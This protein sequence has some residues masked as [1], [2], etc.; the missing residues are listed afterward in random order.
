MGRVIGIDLGTTNSAAAYWRKR[1]PKPIHNAKGSPFTPSVVMIEQ[2][3][4]I[5]GQDAKERMRTG[6]KNIV[7]STKRF[8]GRDYDDEIVQR[9]LEHVGY[10][11]RKA[12]NGEVEVLLDGKYYSPVEIS[13]MIL[14]QLKKDAEVVL[15]EEVTHAVI[16]VPAYF[17]QRQKNATREAGQLAG[18]KVLR[19]INEPTAAAL[20]FGV[21]EESDEPQRILVYDLGGGTF[22]ISILVVSG[23]NFDVLHIAGDN[24]LGGDDFDQLIVDEMLAKIQREYGEDL[25]QDDGAKYILKGRA[26]QE[27]KIELS[28]E[29]EAR[30]PG[31]AAFQTRQGKPINIDY[32]ITRAHFEELVEDLVQRSVDITYRALRD[33]DIEVEDIDRVLLVGGMTRVPIIRKRLK[34]IFGDKIEIDVDPMQCVALGAAV[35]TTIPIEWLCQHCDAVNKGIE[36]TCY[37][38]GKPRELGDEEQQPH[39]LCDECGKPNRQG[40]RECWNCGAT[41]GAVFAGDQV[42][43]ITDIT[44]MY[45]GVET[46]D[47][48]QFA[49]VIPKSTLYPTDEPFK[50]EL[51]TSSFGREYY[52]LPVYELETEDAPREKWEHIAVMY[53]DRLPPGLPSNTPVMVEMRIDGDGILTVRSFV[54]KLEDET[55]IEG[56]FIFAGKETQEKPLSEILENLGFFIFY[57]ESVAQFPFLKK[58][59]NPGQ[60]EQALQLVAEAKPVLEMEDQVRAQPLLGRMQDLAKNFPV[61]TWDVFWAKWAAEDPKTSAI[62]RS[63]A[64]QI[65]MQMERAASRADYD[66]AN[67]HLEQLRQKRVEMFEK[68]PSDLLKQMR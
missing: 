5:V 65:I 45:I 66:T 26:E 18:L 46:I 22:D 47:G 36:E 48:S 58:Y 56:K 32:T 50:R 51:F 57:L 10:E 31:G 28:R 38:C 11:T 13:A 17:G 63:Q 62:D 43:S 34:E 55:L 67:Q 40:R 2:G 29:K 16:T 3:R 39:I 35:Q 14:E 42:A 21:E 44:P 59:L 20:A 19:I 30:I 64:E 23:G 24:F 25:S 1:R 12:S 54:R 68:L 8:I 49:T 52:R 9:A 33:D 61:P 53:N 7:Y 27:A 60:A 4:R 6:S 41:I 15:G 37:S